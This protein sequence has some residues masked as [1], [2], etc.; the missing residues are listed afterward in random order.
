MCSVLSFSGEWSVYIAGGVR[1]RDIGCFGHM[2][3]SR[4]KPRVKDA[5]PYGSAP[6]HVS[7]CVVCCCAC[8][9]VCVCVCVQIT[10]TE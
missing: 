4:E 5:D 7:T 9:C 6:C 3:G 2:T 10:R 8:V 1:S